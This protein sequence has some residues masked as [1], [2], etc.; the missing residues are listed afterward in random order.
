MQKPIYN[1]L[2][3]KFFND[4]SHTTFE[5]YHYKTFKYECHETINSNFNS[6]S[7]VGII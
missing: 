1:I 4:N 3:L 6:N 5:T 7:R 2:K